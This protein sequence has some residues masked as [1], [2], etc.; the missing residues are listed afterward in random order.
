MKTR[1][2]LI[3]RL[4][5]Q[6]R[7]LLAAAPV[8]LTFCSLPAAA[9]MTVLQVAP[10]FGPYGGTGW[11]MR[12]GAEI[13]FSEVNARGG[14]AGQK[15]KLVT[16]P[17]EAGDVAAQLRTL[18]SQRQPVALFGMVG[19]DT[20]GA[21]AKSGV[22]EQTG[23]ALVGARV[24]S[25]QVGE[26]ARNLFLTRSGMNYEIERLL[27]HLSTSGIKSVGLVYEDDAYGREALAIAQRLAPG[28][29][30]TLVATSYLAGSALVDTAVTKMLQSAPQAVVLASQ[31]AG[32]AAFV[33]RYRAQG[34]LAT[35]AAMS[36]V[37]GSAL[38]KIIGK[39]SSHGVAVVEVAPNTLNESVPLVR[40]F[41]QAYK[42]YGLAD[43]E[44]SQTMMEAYVAART[45][46]EGLKRAGG[47]KAKLASAL[48][49]MEKTDIGGINVDF[50]DGHSVGVRFAELAVIDR[51]G[52][53][54][55]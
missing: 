3:Q 35:I 28:S 27:K 6:V 7:G 2:P 11:H 50:T 4:S 42:K 17:Q 23:L 16:V 41:R 20:V 1:K 43:I 8:A 45:L 19:D 10:L 38:P 25:S 9:D 48:S 36:F 53:V 32:A 31:T 33:Q 46:V 51:N 12:T 49:G 55:R 30:V 34:G 21:V 22:L 5:S 29:Q 18:N 37:E 52:R 40:D 24:S 26:G 54:I 15:I 39:A 14:I 44:P 13:Y 47:A